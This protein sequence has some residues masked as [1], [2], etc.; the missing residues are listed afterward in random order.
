MKFSIHFRDF[1]Y[2]LHL[3]AVNSLLVLLSVH[4]FSQQPTE[5]SVIFRYAANQIRLH[6]NTILPFSDIHSISL[7]TG[8]SIKIK[9]QTR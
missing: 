5:K 3:E 9:M 7:K 4:L 6:K 1:T 8:Q 2:H